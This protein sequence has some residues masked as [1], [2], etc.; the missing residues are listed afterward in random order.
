MYAVNNSINFTVIKFN[1]PIF[2]ELFL[3]DLFVNKN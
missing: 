3:N 2:C 1:I